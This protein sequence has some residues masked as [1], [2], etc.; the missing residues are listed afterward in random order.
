[1]KT[2]AMMPGWSAV[3]GQTISPYVGR[4]A[5]GERLLGH[6]VRLPYLSLP[7]LFPPDMHTSDILENE[8]AAQG[9]G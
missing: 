4:I 6:S 5:E 7:Y 1:M 3:A 9:W 2:P 8:V